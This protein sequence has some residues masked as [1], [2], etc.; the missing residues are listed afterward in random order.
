MKLTLQTLTGTKY[1]LEVQPQDKVREVRVKIFQELGIKSKVRL[2]WQNKQM[3]DSST[4]R[5]LG[6]AEDATIQMVIE[7]DV[8]FKVTI[9]TFKKGSIAVEFSDSDTVID[10]NKTLHGSTLQST[11]KISDFYFGDIQ[12]SKEQLPFHFYGI[13]DG[14]VIRQHYEGLFKL[15]LIDARTYTFVRLI[16]VSGTD[17]V[18]ELNVKVLETINEL[19]ANDEGM[20][21]EDDITIF[22][23]KAECDMARDITIYHELD[24][25]TCTL[26][27]CNIEP[28][29][30]VT[31]IRYHG[32]PAMRS[33]ADIKIIQDQSR[34]RVNKVLYDLYNL[35]SVQSLR[36]KIQHQL[37]IPLEMQILSIG[38]MSNRPAFDKK[39]SR[40]KFEKIT[41]TIDNDYYKDYL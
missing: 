33:D 39:V 18:K 25:G 20:L 14:S 15:H 40:D 4:L 41:V 34:K 28:L 1:F 30:V 38:G 16:T 6:V 35:E 32:D 29:D 9:Q 31:F 13:C 7:P 21:V 19:S 22:H 17:T 12:L 36:L 10:L 23:S 26:T 5:S 24:R 8:K 11:A 3:E 37:H 2:L 27:E